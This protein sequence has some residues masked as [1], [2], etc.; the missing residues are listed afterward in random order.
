MDR[1]GWTAF[2]EQE[3]DETACI[4][5]WLLIWHV[6]RGVVA[7]KWENRH[8][9]PMYTHWMAMPTQ[10]WIPVSSRKPSKEDADVMNCVLASH[11]IDGITVTGWHQFEHDKYLTH[12]MR[13]PAPPVDGAAYKARF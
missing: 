1:L 10:G 4:Q 3:P 8:A 11:M 2:D 13:T 12:W 6:F 7:E 9:T 5:G